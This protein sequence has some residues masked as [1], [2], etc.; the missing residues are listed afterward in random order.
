MMIY[1]YDKNV[2]DVSNVDYPE[3]PQNKTVVLFLG[4]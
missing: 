2:M 1:L 3:L 4:W